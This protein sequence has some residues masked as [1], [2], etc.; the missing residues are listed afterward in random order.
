MPT[1]PDL[2]ELLG[3]L[4]EGPLEDPPW[5]SFL[6]LLRSVFVA[7]AVTL[8]LNAPLQS[9]PD[10]SAPVAN[11]RMQLLSDGGS[12]SHI[13]SY[14]QGQFLLDPMVNLPA[15]KV[16][17]L[18]EFM[19]EAELLAS[20]FY[21]VILAP[22][23]WYDF[24]AVDLRVNG[25][26]D[27]RMRIGRYRGAPRFGEAEKQRLQDL[28]PHIERAI[29]LHTRVRRLESE[30]AVYAGVVAQ[31]SVATILLDENGT[32]VSCNELAEALLAEGDGITA[33][34]GHLVLCKREQ[35]NELLALVSR[36]FQAQQHNDIMAVEALRV[37]RPSGAG[38]LGVLIRPVPGAEARQVHSIP[39]VAIFISNPESQAEAPV[40][41]ITRLF[42]LTP[43]EA[44]LTM[45]LT[46]GLT[47]D[48]AS[49]ELG[50]SRNTTR[51]HLRS[52]FSKTGVSRQT[53]LVRLIL[54]SVAPLA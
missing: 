54:K 39:T 35:T 24:L 16:I 42:G 12:T 36:V 6:T 5:S 22:Q 15:G 45:L 38:D 50:V 31:M 10:S 7:D 28:L 37:E 2:G 4:Y 20:E 48:E 21:Q 9:A 13:E 53:M 32:I 17:S 29:R 18:R 26:I 8:L 43:T 51:T 25:E 23:N 46:N 3:A 1:D 11:S 30:R 52:V 14:T 34:D 27:A 33:S 41:V 44:A 19:S 47:L 40:Q 49:L